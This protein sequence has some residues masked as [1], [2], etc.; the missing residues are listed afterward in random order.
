MV[1]VGKA[2]QGG[3]GKK[4]LSLVALFPTDLTIKLTDSKVVLHHRSMLPTARHS[5][6]RMG[7]VNG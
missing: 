2:G 6:V 4:Y 5:E 7:G 3:N 1:G